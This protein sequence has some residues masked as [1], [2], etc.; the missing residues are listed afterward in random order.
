MDGLIAMIL[1]DRLF[2]AAATGGNTDATHPITYSSEDPSKVE[3]N[4]TTGVLTFKKAV[5]GAAPVVIKATVAAHGAYPVQTV[6]TK[7]YILLDI[8]HSTIESTVPGKTE[9]FR[10][11]TNG[12]E[13]VTVSFTPRDSSGQ[14]MREITTSMVSFGRSSEGSNL[15]P[16]IKNGDTFSVTATSV[17]TQATNFWPVING[18]A[19]GEMHTNMMYFVDNY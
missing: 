2:S 12:K 7:V 15:S 8:S 6:T 9:P 1:G 19:I 16:I 10:V 17:V 3:V 4:A 11:L 18:V 14:P 5:T 13:A